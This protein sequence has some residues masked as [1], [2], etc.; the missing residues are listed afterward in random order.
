MCTE[1][2]YLGATYI[3]YILLTFLQHLDVVAE[4]DVCQVLDD[5]VKSLAPDVLDHLLLIVL[6][7]VVEHVVRTALGHD[8]HAVFGASCADDGSSESSAIAEK[9][10]NYIKRKRSCPIF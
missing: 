9:K 1:L 8:V 4:I 6:V 7:I 5:D 10:E 2:Y 3:R